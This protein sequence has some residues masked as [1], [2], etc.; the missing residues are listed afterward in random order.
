MIGFV[1][2]W[3]K[4]PHVREERAALAAVMSRQP[5]TM[6]ELKWGTREVMGSLTTWALLMRLERSGFVSRLYLPDQ[7]APGPLVAHFSLT[8]AGRDRLRELM[9]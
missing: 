3:F 2:K 1:L 7:S 9:R 6:S 5:A 4:A 8:E